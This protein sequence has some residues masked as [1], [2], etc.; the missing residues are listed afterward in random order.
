MKKVF[1]VLLLL[2]LLVTAYL[3]GR[4]H[5]PA[6]STRIARHVLYY[7]D[8]MH[9][10]YKSDKPG[11]AP[12][13]GMQLEPVYSGDAGGLGTVDRGGLSPEVVSINLDQQQ[14]IGIRLVEATRTADRNHL[15][16]PGRVVADETRSYR[17]TA[18]TDGLV[19]TTFDHSAG[20]F[21]KEGGGACNLRFSRV[22]YGGTKLS[23]KLVARS[24]EQ[25]RVDSPDG[26]EGSAFDARGEPLAHLGLDRAATQGVAHQ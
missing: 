12:D 3:A 1:S 17:L 15:T 24:G 8:P 14:L 18:G 22:P 5:A 19:L 26:M 23:A 10:S 16:A 13:C 11:T 20:S 21:R 4:N 9:P 7:V 2:L 25:I 6:S